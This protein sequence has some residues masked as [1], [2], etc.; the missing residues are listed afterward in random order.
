MWYFITP[1]IVYGDDALSHLGTISGKKAFIVTDAVMLKLGVVDKVKAQLDRAEIE[2]QVFAEVEPNPSLETVKKGARTAAQFE[3]DW[4]IG[5]GGGSAMDAAKAIRVLCQRLD[6]EPEQVNPIE[7]LGLTQKVRLIT[8]PTTSGTGA[9]VGWAFVLTDHRDQR[10][11][12]LGTREAYPDLA[13]VDPALSAG[14]P[15]QLTADT[16]M[17]ALVHAIEIYAGNWHN[18]FVDGPALRAVQIV[19]D[20]LPRAYANGN[21]M[22]AREHMANAA[23]LAGFGLGNANVGLAHS[24]GHA[25]GALFRVPHGRLVGLYLPYV[26]EFVARE[27]PGRYAELARSVSIDSKSDREAARAFIGRVRD[28]LQRVNQPA[29]LKQIGISRQDFDAKLDALIANAEADACIIGS[30]R[31]PSS[32]ELRRLLE[33]AYEG[34]QVDF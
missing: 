20:Y 12:V 23:T 7:P 16:G 17:D 9:E 21:D 19:F 6:L 30:A 31:T 2:T 1:T 15:P 14:M 10:K 8:I 28:L 3:P 33:C 11:L 18:D 32:E 13:I 25:T 22:E 27:S 26:M 29:A 34:K 4:V 5:L 24:M